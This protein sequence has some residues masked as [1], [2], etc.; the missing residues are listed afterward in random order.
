MNNLKWFLISNETVKIRIPLYSISTYTLFEKLSEN[1]I[2]ESIQS[3]I[4][5]IEEY[6]E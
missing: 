1:S 2:V 5:S 6:H 4:S 3:D